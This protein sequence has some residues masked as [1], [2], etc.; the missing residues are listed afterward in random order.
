MRLGLV[1]ANA[2]ITAVADQI[3][4]YQESELLLLSQHYCPILQCTSVQKR[5]ST[6]LKDN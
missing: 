5:V 6:P 4:F 1:K 2:V 3:F